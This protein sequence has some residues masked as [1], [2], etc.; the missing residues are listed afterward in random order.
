VWSR[1]YLDEG[2][3]SMDL[4]RGGVVALPEEETQRRWKATT[5]EW[6]IMHALLYGVSRDQLMAKHKSNHITVHYAPDAA[7]GNEAMFAKA[8]MAREMGMKVHIC[9]K[10][11]ITNSIEHKIAKGTPIAGK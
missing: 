2:V 9:G 1:I 5:A 3:L 7:T 8:A 10:H 4:G 11:G 6:P